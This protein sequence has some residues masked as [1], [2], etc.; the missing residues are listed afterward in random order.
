MAADPDVVAEFVVGS[1]CP[2][3]LDELEERFAAVVQD[4]IEQSGGADASAATPVRALAVCGNRSSVGTN[5]ATVGV[6]ITPDNSSDEELTEPLSAANLVVPGRTA[7]LRF[8]TRFIQT[9]TA[10]RFARQEKTQG[11]ITLTDIGVELRTNKIVNKARG[12]FDVPGPILPAVKFTLTIGDRLSLAAAGSNPPLTNTSSQDLDTGGA[13]AAVVK[14]LLSLLGGVIQP[15]FGNIVFFRFDSL[16]EG[17]V[18]KQ[19]SVGGAL[20]AQW[21]DKVLTPIKPPFL[22][23]KFVLTWTDLS[24]DETGVL[25]RGT[26]APAERSP[27]A[28]ILG[29]RDVTIFKAQGH[30]TVHYQVQTQDLF[31]PRITWSGAASGTGLKKTVT[32]DTPGQ[33]EIK[34]EASDRDG[35]SASHRIRIDV[36][37]KVLQP[38]EQ[39][40]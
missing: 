35:F 3:D 37:V 18:G 27:R 21:P 14:V 15:T 24:V 38:G 36:K 5:V 8:T 13:A 39:P 10:L 1:I 11:R 17:F 19:D 30:T 40:Q 20:A 16:A 6:W 2:P 31:K 4:A 34:I 26:F 9:L 12:K 22:P 25:T 28:N 33:V 23:G 7:A 29:P 32:F